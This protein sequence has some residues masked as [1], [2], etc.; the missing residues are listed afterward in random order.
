MRVINLQDD[1][2]F[3]WMNS[4]LQTK[5]GKEL[6]LLGGILSCFVAIEFFE[7]LS[8]AYSLVD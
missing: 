3:G 7:Y 1:Q 6:T 8:S 2:C 5:D 4:G